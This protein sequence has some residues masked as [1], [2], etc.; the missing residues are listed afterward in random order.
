VNGQTTL[1]PQDR[2]DVSPLVGGSLRRIAVIE[3][4]R[5][6]KGQT[7]AWIE[8]T[9]IVAMQKEYLQSQTRY[10]QASRELERQRELQ[11]NNA[12]VGRNLH[13]AESDYEIARSAVVGL[14]CQLRQLGINESE[15]KRGN[16]AT[17]IPVRSP[18]GGFV[19][20]IYKSTGSYANAEQP[21][22]TIVDDSKMHIDINVYEK[23]MADLKVGQ[24]VDF[25][26]TNNPSAHLSGEIYEFAS[27]FTDK[28]KSLI[29]HVR[30][31]NRGNAAKLI[32]GM[33]VTGT[34]QKGR[35]EVDAVPSEAITSSEGKSFVFVLDKTEG[36]G[37]RKTYSFRRAEVATGAE[38]LGYTQ[39]KP[40]AGIAPNAT[41]VTKGAFYL[42]SMLGEE[43]DHGH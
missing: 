18:I 2:A 10:Q 35:S 27:S 25:V 12:G 34:V 11:S 40:V 13:Q 31:T 24:A 26:L 15:V 38:E 9:E 39:V 32:P 16:I 41:I 43:A 4:S 30:I 22:L 37:E 5:V 42:S 19:D 29:A 23:D 33:Y 7:V 28:S 36:G 17:R 14:G 21:V 1:N 3:G 6:A 20:K 8:N